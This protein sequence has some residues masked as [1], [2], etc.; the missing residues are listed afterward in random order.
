M[1]EKNLDKD[2]DPKQEGEI[3][4]V[5]PLSGMYERINHESRREALLD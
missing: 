4:E 2:L 1:D 5:I 3:R